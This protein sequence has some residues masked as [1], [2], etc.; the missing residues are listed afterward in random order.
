MKRGA[1]VLIAIVCTLLLAPAV[2][3]LIYDALVFWPHRDEMRAVLENADPLDR[4]PPSKVRAYIRSQHD[5]ALPSAVV[6]RQLQSRWLP[7][8]GMLDW[9][10]RSFLWERL[11]SLHLSQ[12]EVLGLYATLAYNGQG[13]GQGMNSLSQ[14]LFT[15]PLDALS[16]EDAAMVVAY[17]WAP[18]LYAQHPER[19]RARTDILLSRV[20]STQLNAL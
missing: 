12:E 3:F 7:R 11:V 6:A 2:A 5:G 18:E 4:S 20:R 17:T 8:K 16:D 9:H 13:Q 14:R 10:V 1:K 19:P 15:K